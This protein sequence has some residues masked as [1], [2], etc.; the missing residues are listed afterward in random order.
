MK[1]TLSNALEL[2]AAFQYLITKNEPFPRKFS[3]AIA[4]NTRNLIRTVEYFEDT[5]NI[6]LEKYGTKDENDK[7]II[8]NGNV[9]VQ[10]IAGYN[11]E[12]KLIVESEVTIDLYYV[13]LD[14]LPENLE[15]RI[16]ANLLPIIKND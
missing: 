2:N 4:I 10:D 12:I 5:K 8:E 6:L 9:Q 3:Y 11:L 7:L 14:D 1:L 15:P 13:V 16:V